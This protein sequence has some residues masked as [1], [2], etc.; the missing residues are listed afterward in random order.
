[1]HLITVKKWHD[2]I[3]DEPWKAEICAV[4][5][6]DANDML[7][8]L[9][10]V[11]TDIGHATPEQ[12]AEALASFSGAQIGAALLAYRDG[13]ARSIAAGRTAGN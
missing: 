6:K 9:A 3:A 4:A 1:M 8:R 12:C 7:Q 10:Y 11:M 13:A 2:G 5:I